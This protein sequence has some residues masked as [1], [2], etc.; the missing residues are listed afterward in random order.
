MVVGFLVTPSSGT[1]PRW[2]AP[3]VIFS[4]L[5]CG[6]LYYFLFFHAWITDED[7]SRENVTEGDRAFSLFSLA[8]V[9]VHVSKVPY[10]DIEIHENARRFG[11]RRE[12]TYYVSYLWQVSCACRLTFS[13]AFG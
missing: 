5:L 1:I 12:V 3:L 2:V 10:Y 9:K 4:L 13:V 7:C 6:M 8:G 11:S